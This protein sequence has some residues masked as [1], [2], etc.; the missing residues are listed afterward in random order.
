MKNATCTCQPSFKTVLIA[1][2]FS[3][4]SGAAFEAALRLCLT[5]KANLHI[6][7]VFEYAS[8][9]A[10]ESGGLLLEI[11]IF[12]QR[13]QMSLDTL[14]Q[15]ARQVGIRCSGA[16]RGGIAHATI[17]ETLD[18]QHIDLAVLG[19]RSLHGFE[20]LVFG[21]T[22]E[23]VI[24]KANCP[25]FTVGPQAALQPAHATASDGTVVFATDFQTS[26]TDALH[27]ASFF[28]TMMQLPLHCL[29][30]LPRALEGDAPRCAVPLIITEAL[31]HLASTRP[32]QPE[33]ICAVSY[34]SEVSNAVLEYARKHKA[35]LIVLGVRRASLA[36]SH[37]PAH[38]AYRV[39][40]EAPC[41][42][43]TVA[44]PRPTSLA[45]E[46]TLHANHSRSTSA[47]R[48]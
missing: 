17:L 29:H 24:R 19:T 5:H 30:V 6:L 16:I 48:A 28:S 3:A 21:S 43:L 8:I 38:I 37:V 20:R 39:I 4:A 23:A 11:D 14:L 32:G 10:P 18:A 40:T 41:P 1:T 46:H 35:K 36:A 42:L 27:Y 25:V 31:Q 44:Y 13:A 33:P 26:T 45:D 15:E 47:L 12:Y 34:G 2:D 7:H 22:A 9:P